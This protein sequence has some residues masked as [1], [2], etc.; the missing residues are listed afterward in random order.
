ML[1][2]SIADYEKGSGE[3]S[4]NKV[5]SKA[6]Y[7]RGMCRVMLGLRKEGRADLEKSNELNHSDNTIKAIQLCDRIIQQD[8]TFKL[9]EATAVQMG[10]S[11]SASQTEILSNADV[12][13]MSQ[14]K[15]S[16]SLI[17]SKIKNSTCSFDV[18]TKGLLALKKAGVSDA[19]IEVM[20]QRPH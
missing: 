17:N 14:A 6:Y 5:L 13:A 2:T 18:T 4:D 16:D 1:D 9:Q 3:K 20:T 12:I 15:M 19:V 11:T 7:N 8:D 10:G